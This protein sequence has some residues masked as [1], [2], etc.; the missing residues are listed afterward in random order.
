MAQREAPQLAHIADLD[1]AVA[2]PLE[3]GETGVGQRR[4][5]AINGGTVS[6]AVL[7]G[8]I[9]PGGA[10]IQIIR[11]DGL[12]E[13]VARYVIE[14]DDGALVYV[15]NRGMRD[16]P[17]ELLEKLRRGEAVDPSLIYFRTA[18]RFETAAPRLKFLTRRLFIGVGA[19]YPNRVALTFWTVE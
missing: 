14:A 6:G 5:I 15:E 13:L 12:T 17:P 1:I 2:Q 16:G 7:N 19:R 11:P 3:V 4:V 10:D 18:P 8:R 9:L